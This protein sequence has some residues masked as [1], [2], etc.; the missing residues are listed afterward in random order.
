MHCIKNIL[1]DG[2]DGMPLLLDLFFEDANG[3]K[4]VVIYAHGFNGFK[5]WGNCDLVAE[6]FANAGFVFLKFNFSHNGTAPENPEEFSD[7]E[8]FGNNNYSIELRDLEQI[9]NWVCDEL[10]PYSAAMNIREVYLTGHSMG[11]GISILYAAK[12]LRIKKLI[13]WAAINECKTPWGNWPEHKIKEWK[14]TGV[15]YYINTRTK[16]ELPLY[17]QLHEDYIKNSERLDIKKAIQNLSIPILICHGSLDTSVP[18]QKA[19]ELK[20]WQPFAEI[21]IIETDHGFGRSHP[22]TKEVVPAAM[23][24]IIDVSILFLNKPASK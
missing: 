5:D 20:S 8:A 6:Q 7:L 18:V 4:P 12:D 13:T 15:A 9:T 16:Q 2:A 11:G 24:S 10:N 1:L 17:Y 21:F 14:D 22:W 23:Q 19:I 3:S